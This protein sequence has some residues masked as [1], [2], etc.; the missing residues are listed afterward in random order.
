MNPLNVLGLRILRHNEWLVIK[1]RIESLEHDKNETL[2]YLKVIENSNSQVIPPSTNGRSCEVVKRLSSFQESMA[3]LV[4]MNEKTRWHD[5]GMA[6]FNEILTRQFTSDQEMYDKIVS[7]LA[8]YVSANQAALFLVDDWNKAEPTVCLEACY[9]YD[10]KKSM[11][12]VFHVGDNLIGQCIMDRSTTLVTHIPQF[13]TKI[14]SGLGEATPGCLLVVPLQDDQ[15]CIG[16][17]ELAAFQ[18]FSATEIQLVE[19]LSKS[20]TARICNMRQSAALKELFT[21]SEQAQL[22]VRAKES[23]IRRQFEQLQATHEDMARKSTELE[24]M[25]KELETKNAEIEQMRVQE[26]ELLESKLDAQRRS[27]EMIIDRLRE[28]LAQRNTQIN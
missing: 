22:E 12:K 3:T 21:R 8:R 20:I 11:Q 26:K 5:A 27:Y 16:A 9:A 1:N 13:Y 28:K 6:A 14:T 23:E 7:A 4:G 24:Y 10:R 18:K 19:A 25:R 15:Q 2:N 17:I